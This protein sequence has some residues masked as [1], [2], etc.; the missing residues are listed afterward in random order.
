MEYPISINGFKIKYIR[1]FHCRSVL[2]HY[3]K[4]G[5]LN[6]KMIDVLVFSSAINN[7]IFF[8]NMHFYN[9]TVQN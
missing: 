2:E 3:D 6:K 5:I 1:K 7:K 8:L 4:S 9:F